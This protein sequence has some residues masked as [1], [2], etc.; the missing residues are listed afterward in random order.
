MQK[1]TSQQHIS[2]TSLSYISTAMEQLD[3]FAMLHGIPKTLSNQTRLILIELLHN[4]FKHG[5]EESM[6]Q[7]IN[8]QLKLYDQGRF[9]VKITHRGIAYNPFKYS[10]QCKH[11]ESERSLGTLALHLAK[12]YMDK[13]SYY[14]ALDYNV[15]FLSKERV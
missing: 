13:V 12:K 3:A 11:F 5:F 1:L 2:I 15:I 8:L 10:I 9:S 4:M 6:P 14:L 7:R